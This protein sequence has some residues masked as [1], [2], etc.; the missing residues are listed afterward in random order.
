MEVPIG[1]VTHY[2][3]K[4]GVA[5]VTLTAP[6]KVGDRV[7]VKGRDQEWEQE[8]TSMEIDR[9]PVSESAAGSEV[10]IKVSA[11]VREGALLIIEK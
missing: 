2:Y 1:K 11:R 3:G 7:K 8:I 6:L 9:K 4:A 10:A 5:V